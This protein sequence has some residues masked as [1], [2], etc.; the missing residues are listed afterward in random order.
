MKEPFFQGNDNYD[1]LE[2]I[3]RVL[4]TNELFD[5]LEKYHIELDANYEGILGKHNKKHFSK[6]VTNENKHL[7]KNDAVDLLSKMLIYDHVRFIYY[8]RV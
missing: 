5:Y 4:G 2:K 6:F 8:L 7:A 3:A 1:Q